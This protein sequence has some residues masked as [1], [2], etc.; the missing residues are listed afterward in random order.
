M[1]DVAPSPPPRRQNG[2]FSFPRAVA[3]PLVPR[4]LVHGP[5]AGELHK[6]ADFWGAFTENCLVRGIGGGLAGGVFGF[7][8]GAVFSTGMGS[9]SAH[10][11]PALRDWQAT[12]AARGPGMPL[13][14]EPPKQPLLQVLREGL[15]EVRWRPPLSPPRL[16]ARAPSARRDSP[17]PP[18]STAPPFPNPCRVETAACR[19]AARLR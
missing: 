11:D 9:L 1:T 16:P 13:P 10:H 4:I 14:P 3:L 18:P 5:A 8:F 12:V 7:V 2:I 6:E 17:N 15:V 19:R